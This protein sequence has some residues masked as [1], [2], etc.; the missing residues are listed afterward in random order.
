MALAVVRFHLKTV[1]DGPAKPND[2]RARLQTLHTVARSLVV[3]LKLSLD[4]NSLGIL[5]FNSCFAH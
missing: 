2:S 3:C 1:P 5:N 4:Y